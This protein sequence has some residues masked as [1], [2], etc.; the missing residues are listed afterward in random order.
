MSACCACCRCRTTPTPG[1]PV[2]LSCSPPRPQHGPSKWAAVE[3][4]GSSPHTLQTE[5]QRLRTTTTFSGRGKK[6]AVVISS[7]RQMSSPIPSLHLRQPQCQ[8]EA[9]ALPLPSP[10]F[11]FLCS[12]GSTSL[13]PGRPQQSLLLGNIAQQHSLKEGQSK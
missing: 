7:T 3:S 1:E 5:P 6:Q 2:G 12:S 10:I 13:G 11:S 8:A 9:T 4:R